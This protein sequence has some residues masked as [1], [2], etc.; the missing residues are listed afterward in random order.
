MNRIN[1]GFA[2]PPLLLL[3]II[4][5]FVHRWTAEPAPPKPPPTTAAWREA[6]GQVSTAGGPAQPPAASSIPPPAAV[7][8]APAGTPN[9]APPGNPPTGATS[10]APSGEPARPQ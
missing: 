6:Q 2:I 5:L 1:L 7:N 4:G 3:V 9:V 10:T 8:P